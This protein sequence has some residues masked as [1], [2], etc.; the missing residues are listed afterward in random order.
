MFLVTEPSEL[1]A[2]MRTAFEIAQRR[3]TRRGGHTQ[4]RRTDRPLRLSGMLTLRGY[5]RRIREIQMRALHRTCTRILD[6]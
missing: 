3:P 2:T 1:E 4:G 5:D 6:F